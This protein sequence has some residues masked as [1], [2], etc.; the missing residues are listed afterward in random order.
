MAKK[1][2]QGIE[3]QQ[4]IAELTAPAAVTE[5]S[6]PAASEPVTRVV[7][8]PST[9]ESATVESEPK[10]EKTIEERLAKVRENKASRRADAENL[11]QKFNELNQS[12]KYDG[13]AEVGVNKIK[14]IKRI[15]YGR[16]SNGIAWKECS[17]MLGCT[18]NPMLSAVRQL[19]YKV[20]RTVDGKVEGSDI[21]VKSL[22][23]ID[24]PINLLQLH[25]DIEGGIGHDSIL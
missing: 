13:L 6:A 23:E 11:I 4:E 2:K 10:T 20:I 9:V 14:V 19:T 7:S 21:P 25:K 8:E 18:E 24:K 16:N 17:L 22:E 5:E 15:M 3:P 12:K 1:N